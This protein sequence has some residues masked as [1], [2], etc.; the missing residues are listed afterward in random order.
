MAIFDKENID[1]SLVPLINN[2]EAVGVVKLEGYGKTSVALKNDEL[3]FKSYEGKNI[4]KLKLLQITSLAFHPGNFINEPKLLIG[5]N[6]QTLEIKGVDDNDTEF[7]RFYNTILKAKKEEPEPVKYETPDPAH[8]QMQPPYDTAPEG[9]RPTGRLPENEELRRSPMRRLHPM[10]M[11]T[12]VLPAEDTADA[13]RRFHEL[14]KDGI[15]T[16]EEF[17]AKKQRLLNL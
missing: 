3:V 7:E 17:E 5:I 6:N 9:L 8:P 16:K 10:N 13:I 4:P 11:D 1:P 14:Y 15:I 12:P 2:G